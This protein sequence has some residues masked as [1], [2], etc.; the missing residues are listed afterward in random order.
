VAGRHRSYDGPSSTP[1]RRSGGSG[2]SSFPTGLV[3]VGAVLV[4]AAGGGYVLY[5]KKHDDRGAAGAASTVTAGGSSCPGGA[6]TALNVDASPDIYS[7][8]KAV[9]DGMTGCVKVNVTSAESAAVGAFLA[10][11]AKGGDVTSAPDVWI[12]DS[13]MWLD[14]AR[15]QGVK[16]LVDNPLPVALSP[17]VIGMPK[18]VADA[19]GW[20]GKKFGWAD[21]LAGVKAGKLQP[22]VP[23]PANSG[24]GL[25]AIT[26]LRGAVV[27][28]A[29]ATGDKVKQQQALQ[30]LTLVYRV[31]SNNLA[32]SMTSLLTDLPSKGATAPS[33]GGVAAFPTTEQKVAAYNTASPSTHLVALYPYEG[34]TMMDYP[35]SIRQGLNAD[36]AKAAADFQTLLH[37]PDAVNTLQK[38]GFRDTKGAAAGILTPAEG[39]N[40]AM[41]V[42]AP[43]DGTH[44]AAASSL[45]IWNTTSEQTRGLVVMDISGSM[46]LPVPGQF[47]ANKNPLTRLQITEAAC[48]SGLALFGN[49]S[50]LGLWTFTTKSKAD[51]GGTVHQ[52]VVPM[53]PLSAPLGAADRRAALQS[54]LQALTVQPGSRNGLYDTILDAYKTVLNGWAENKSNAIVV[55]TDGKD[56]GL[57]SMSADELIAKLNALK[58]ANPGHTVRVMVVALGSGVDLSTLTRITAAASGQALHAETPA[59]IGNAVMAGFAGRL[60]DQ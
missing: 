40:P 34:T 57:N 47:D 16:T 18:P 27:G 3:A 39:V 1:R 56:D 5:T 59:D 35:Y 48:Q 29:A 6:V 58:A 26:M 14:I 55:F 60:N 46:G 37:S 25:A 36:Q 43:P 28:P 49:N 32:S 15:G 53:G 2:G 33:S 30:N 4:L 9:A 12:P 21:L 13:S 38:A 11:S 44:T 52:E 7:A 23:D 22:E 19:N 41:P 54:A 51:G 24:P 42:T 31:L 10:G 20:P 45:A 8:V 17:L 50:E